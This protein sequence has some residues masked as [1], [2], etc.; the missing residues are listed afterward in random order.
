MILSN[1]ADTKDILLELIT[2]LSDGDLRNTITPS[3]P[4]TS[5]PS[6]TVDISL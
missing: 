2:S 3:S 5:I 4:A 6:I 1:I